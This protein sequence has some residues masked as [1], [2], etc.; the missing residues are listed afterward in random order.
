MVGEALGD[1]VIPLVVTIARR[2]VT[3]RSH[4]IA[5]SSPLSKECSIVCVVRVERDL[6]ITIPGV[7]YTLLGVSWD[8]GCQLER[9]LYWECLAERVFI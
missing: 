8:S 6:V 9:T 5:I 4:S 1:R 2:H 3:L 7:Y